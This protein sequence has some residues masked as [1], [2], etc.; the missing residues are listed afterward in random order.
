MQTYCEGE[1]DGEPRKHVARGPFRVNRKHDVRV[2]HGFEVPG[3]PVAD[4]GAGNVEREMGRARIMMVRERKAYSD[5]SAELKGDFASRAW[6]RGRALT[7]IVDHDIR[8]RV[9]ER[10]A[11][12]HPGRAQT[13][14]CLAQHVELRE[15]DDV[16]LLGGLRVDYGGG[17]GDR[18]VRHFAVQAGGRDG[19]EVGGVGGGDRDA[20][21]WRKGLGQA[22]Q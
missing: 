4:A 11:L 14:A 15:H 16:G 12:L 22:G 1:E 20:V 17:G 13:P 7:L 10:P 21:G 8:S 9:I 6:G 18:W 3:E 19:G 5:R 2:E